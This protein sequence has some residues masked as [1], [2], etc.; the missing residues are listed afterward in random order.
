MK[1]P[2]YLILLTCSLF[3]CGAKDNIQQKAAEDFVVQIMVTGQWAVTAYTKGTAD[4]TSDFAPYRFQF[5]TNRTIDALKNSVVEKSGTWDA[6]ATARTITSNFTSAS[7]PLILLNGTWTITNS[8]LTTVEAAQTINGEERV[9]K[10]A[11][12]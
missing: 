7:T 11:K 5:Q 6:N 4:I 2:L 8:T 10:L 1:N 3:S 9:L 12:Q